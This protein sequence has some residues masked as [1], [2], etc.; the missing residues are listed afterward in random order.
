MARGG[1]AKKLFE[2]FAFFMGRF[3]AGLPVTS[4]VTCLFYGALSGSGPATTAAVGSMVIP[5]LENLGYKRNFAAALV[6]TAG[7]LGII[8]PPSVPFIIFALSANVSVAEMFVAGII[9]GFIIAGCLCGCAYVYCKIK[10]EDREKLNANCDA[11]RA[12]GFFPLLKDSFWALL[13]PVIILGGIY[14]GVF[15]PT[16]AATVSVVYSLI[17]SIGI[18][19]TMRFKDIPDVLF[20]TARSLAPLLIVVAAA[21]LFGRV[22]TL[23][24]VPRDIQAF[25]SNVFESPLAVIF[26]INVVLLISGMLVNC[27][28]A[29]LILTPVLMPVAMSIGMH[30]IH[31]GIMMTVN[32]AIG[33]VTP[34]VGGDLFVTCGMFH[35]PVT[36]LA[37][38]TLPFIL[39]FL[40][41]LAIVSYVPIVSLIFIPH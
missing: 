32:L 29:I 11:I 8:I 41:A 24:Q 34:P 30:P 13:T 1:I 3:T 38:H 20:E 14:G 10:G 22:I 27:L 28:S 17:V 33:L 31:F 26:I 23:M 4:V 7:S 9:P 39:A 18:Y 25:M 12:Q 40:L 36:T 37:K 2:F 15:T 5:Y 6:T 16:E 19:K 21:T 35:I